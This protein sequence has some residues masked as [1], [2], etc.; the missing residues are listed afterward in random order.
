MVGSCGFCLVG[1]RS[2]APRVEWPQPG[3]MITR[4]SV[5]SGRDALRHSLRVM[6]V[7]VMVGCL[8]GLFV[9]L[10]FWGWGVAVDVAQLMAVP[11]AVLGVLG[12]FG[13]FLTKPTPTKAAW[14]A[15]LLLDACAVQAVQA[16]NVSEPIILSERHL[17]LIELQ[18]PR[19][20][21][22]LQKSGAVLAKMTSEAAF[23]MSQSLVDK[24]L[25]RYIS[26][27]REWFRQVVSEH[28]EEISLGRDRQEVKYRFDRQWNTLKIA[29]S[30]NPTLN[31]A[32][33]S[34]NPEHW[35]L[36]GFSSPEEFDDYLWPTMAALA[37]PPDELTQLMLKEFAGGPR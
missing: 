5:L 2:S 21:A 20:R 1:A 16:A 10:I 8:L 29:F 15:V 33:S 17:D 32:L 31:I 18:L 25:P 35:R 19:L 4:V 14:K 37:N 12:G 26:T 13:L 23:E 11:L 28:N 30:K 3:W 24:T 36:F 7:V 22:L 9:A 6:S 34:S 27:Y